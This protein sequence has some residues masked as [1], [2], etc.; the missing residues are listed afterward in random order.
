MSEPKSSEVRTAQVEMLTLADYIATHPIV[1]ISNV[2]VLVC[3]LFMTVIGVSAVEDAKMYS[4]GVRIVFFSVLFVC[5]SLILVG[6]KILVDAKEWRNMDL[7]K[8]STSS[9]KQK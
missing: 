1:Q 7:A 8:Q 5:G 4:T 3:A 6:W 2:F 9:T